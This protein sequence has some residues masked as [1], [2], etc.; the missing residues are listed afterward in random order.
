MKKEMYKNASDM[1]Y[2]RENQ[3]LLY[4]IA[5]V[6]MYWRAKREQP[7]NDMIQLSI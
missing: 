3:Q 2:R 1:Y 7:S 5:K 4:K 6:G